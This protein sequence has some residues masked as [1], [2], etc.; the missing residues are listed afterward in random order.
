MLKLIL[1]SAL[2][3]CFVG[4]VG[5]GGM[6]PTPDAGGPLGCPELAVEPVLHVG[7]VTGNEEWGGG[8]LHKI[9]NTLTIEAGAQITL[10]PCAQVLI[11]PA[12]WL[13]VY[14]KLVARGDAL[15][16]ITIKGDNGRFNSIMV[17]SPGTIDLGYVTIENAGATPQSSFG[18]AILAEGSWPVTRPVAVDH[19][20]INDAAGYGVALRG[21]TAFTPGSAELTVTN[22]GK[23][24]PT[25]PFPVRMELNT[26]G[27]LPTGRYT[28]N[29]IDEIQIVSVPPKYSVEIDDVIRDRGVPYRM[30]GNGSLAE[31]RIGA[32]GSVPTLTIEPGVTIRMDSGTG[33]TGRVYVGVSNQTGALVAVGTADKPIRFTTSLPTPVAGS[34]IGV[35]FTNPVSSTN[36]LEHVIIEYAGSPGGASGYGC[37]PQSL[38]HNDAALRIFSMPPST[39]FQ[40]SVIRHSR[41]HGI[42]SG[43]TGFEVDFKTGNTFENVAGCSQVL[44]K[45]PNGA[46]PSMPMCQ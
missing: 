39:L 21:Y 14:G 20:T 27:S 24:S 1:R 26:T 33:T 18:A 17:R 32:V 16:P 34:W 13:F 29:Q 11:R 12:A 6:P 10:S 9:T 35:D 25:Y 19:V 30:G 38:N 23:V 42:L 2:L 4:F 41:G 22:S 46:C 3:A 36:R 37:P 7:S 40:S 31:L 44:P 43:W 15:H 28:G 8:S 5:C 45:E